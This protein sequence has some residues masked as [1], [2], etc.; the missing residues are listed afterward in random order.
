MV[1]KVIFRVE[2]GGLGDHLFY[3]A[4]PRLLKENKL[5][6]QVYIASNS[7][8]R[9]PQI[10]DLVWK[11][12]PHLDGI[13]DE[14]PTLTKQIS[15]SS[16]NKI[17]NR[18]F[19]QYGIESS[20]ELPVEIYQQVEVL[21]NLVDKYIDLNYVSYVGAF[22][23]FDKFKLYLQYPEHVMINPD[24]LAKILFPGRK[25][26]FTNS[27]MDYAQRIA[28]SSSFVTLASGGASLAAALKKPSTVYYGQGQNPVFHHAI[29]QYIRVG[30]T[31]WLR[32]RLGRFLEKR[33]T[34]RVKS[35]KNK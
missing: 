16:Q 15:N 14:V 7:N 4:L 25:K 32:Y 22:A 13:S 9:N 21:P 31:H 6:D 29:H 30:G 18:I 26:V 1:K 5:A 19:E 3:S 11:N 23:W 12:N 17:V 27:L 35:A 8:F 33:N 10:F 2:Y 24:R 34:K 28:A 20:A